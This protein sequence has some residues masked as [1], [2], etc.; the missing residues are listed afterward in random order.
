MD[1]ALCSLKCETVLD[2]AIWCHSGYALQPCVSL[3]QCVL[4]SKM[5]VQVCVSWWMV[6]K[7][8]VQRTLLVI[9]HGI[10]VFA[11]F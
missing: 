8:E 6:G 1:N 9:S 2:L 4:P 10:Y 5:D 3:P 11:A 7:H